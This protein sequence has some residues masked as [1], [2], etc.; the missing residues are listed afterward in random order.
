M[1]SNTL[2]CVE[3]FRQQRAKKM[4]GFYLIWFKVWVGLKD[5]LGQLH[6]VRLCGVHDL[7][8]HQA[9]THLQQKSDLSNEGK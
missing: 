8:L 9:R 5:L 1:A 4:S 7:S 3:I 6:L 2:Q